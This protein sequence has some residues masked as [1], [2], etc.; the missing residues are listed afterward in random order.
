ME[1]FSPK[2]AHVWTGSPPDHPGRSSDRLESVVERIVR[3]NGII[4]C[5]VKVFRFD[6]RGHAVLDVLAGPEEDRAVATLGCMGVV[7]A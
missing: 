4:A 5:L 2:V 6:L 3:I 1:G 7:G